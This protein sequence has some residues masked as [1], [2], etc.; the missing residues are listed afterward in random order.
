MRVL[1][2]SVLAFE[3]IVAALFIPVA[4]FSGLVTNG[5]T[6]AW[7]GAILAVLCIVAA[8]TIMRPYGVALGWAVQVLFVAA[9][10]IV[11][12]MYILGLVF[13]A[14]W[15]GA[16][17]Y[18]READRARARRAGSRPDAAPPGPPAG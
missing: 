4:Y 3:A 5:A 6:A 1:G 18:G 13:A 15:W 9:G 12:L 7:A 14:L 17:R 2:T 10:L 8:G 16:L 11:P